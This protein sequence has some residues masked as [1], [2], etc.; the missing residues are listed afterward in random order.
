MKYKTKPE[1]EAIET[2]IDFMKSMMTDGVAS[3]S[4]RDK[5]SN[6]AAKKRQEASL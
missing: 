2:D 3:Y 4:G 1:Q 5:K 6:A